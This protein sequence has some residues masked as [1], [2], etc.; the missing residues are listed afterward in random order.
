MSTN[1][2]PSTDR[3]KYDI[4]HLLPRED[5]KIA[6]VPL[7]ATFSEIKAS[8]GNPQYESNEYL[9][10]GG[11]KFHRDIYL[12]RDYRV[13]RIYVTNHD[14]ATARGIAVGDTLKQV[15]AAYGEP[16]YIYRNYYFYGYQKAGSDYIDGI[17]FTH[18][19]KKV[20]QITICN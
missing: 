4:G 10:Y 7:G 13:D 20:T 5:M 6:G 12:Y 19:G 14:A 2:S 15:V 18:N 16:D 3:K 11:I 9:Q 1:A 17:Y 8:L